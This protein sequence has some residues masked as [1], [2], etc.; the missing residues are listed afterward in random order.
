MPSSVPLFNPKPLS[1]I[2]KIGY[3]Q[4]DEWILV[5]VSLHTNTK[6]I[7]PQLTKLKQGKTAF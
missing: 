5:I 3:S 6:M 2:P 4:G 7:N 1:N